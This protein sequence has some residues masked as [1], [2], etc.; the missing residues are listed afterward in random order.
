MHHCKIQHFRLF[1]YH[2]NY[3]FSYRFLHP[4]L[5]FRSH[6]LSPFYH[7]PTKIARPA[8]T[9]NTIQCYFF[10]TW[11]LAVQV[12]KNVI[13]AWTCCVAS[14]TLRCI[15][16]SFSCRSSLRYLHS[17]KISH[18]RDS[19]L[20]KSLFQTR[21]GV[22]YYRLWSHIIAYARDCRSPWIYFHWQ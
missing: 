10:S 17:D 7:P 1:F 15:L 6:D 8:K 12:P 13:Q 19:Q 16:P 20:A 11:T 2:S 21:S 4:F 3:T 9:R 22:T 5:F 14:T 18:K